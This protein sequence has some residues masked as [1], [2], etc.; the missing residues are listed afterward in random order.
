[1]TI[2]A[3]TLA[4]PADGGATVF[5][6]S[7]GS[8]PRRGWAS[9]AL[10]LLEA[11]AAT[12]AAAAAAAESSRSRPATTYLV[13][14]MTLSMSTERALVTIGRGKSSRCMGI[15]RNSSSWSIIKIESFS[16]ALLAVEATALSM[17]EVSETSEAAGRGL[18]CAFDIVV[19]SWEDRGSAGGSAVLFSARDFRT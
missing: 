8:V 15:S 6:G 10:Y 14:A 13:V 16:P 11:A 2:A 5:G 4:L 1:G 19:I 18:P 17:T 3:G 12:A 7:W 9:A